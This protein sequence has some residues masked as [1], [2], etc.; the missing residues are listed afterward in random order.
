MTEMFCPWEP[1]QYL[2]WSANVSPLLYYSHFIAFASALAIGLAVLINNR[3][4]LRAKLLM[5]LFGLFSIWLFVDIVVWATNS[6]SQVMF[7]WSLIVLIEVLIYVTAFYFTFVFIFGKLPNKILNSLSSLILL[8]L[9]ILLPTALTLSGINLYDCVAEEGIMA[10][11]YAYYLEII[12]ILGIA[13]I[14]ISGLR[15]N[16]NNVSKLQI[17]LFTLGIVAFLA[18]FA[19]GNIIG[20]ITGDWDLAQYGL[21]G[22]PIF[23]GF[24]GYLIVKFKLFRLKIFATQA[25][26]TALLVILAGLLFVAETNFTRGVLGVTFLISVILGYILTRSVKKEIQQR[27][28]IEVLAE[29]LKKANARLKILDRMKSEFV[30]IA[31]HQLRSP[32]TSIRG[33]ASMLAE[34]TYG[35]IPKKVEDVLRN[36][37]DSSRFMAQSVEDYLNVSRIEAGNMKYEYSDFNLKDQAERIVDELRQVAMKKGLAM[38]FRSD[39]DGSG[40]VH[41]DIGKVR[42]VIMNLIDNSMKYTKEGSITVLAHDDIKKKTV[43]VTI[44]D[45]GIG[46]DKETLEEV[47]E[48]F[49]RAK[50]ANE[51]NVTGTGL[52][53]FVAKKMVDQMG[54]RVWAESDGEGKG[55]TFHLEFKA[56]T[57][58]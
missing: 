18:A 51:V 29:R 15:N 37:E 28:E 6:A 41:A 12:A 44:Q 40:M 39:I 53:L 35:K 17:I 55:S 1:A 42:Q 30:S 50:N 23:T 22:M 34:G 8:P 52:G 32:L 31:S 49:I 20:S 45:T 4:T 48:K 56:V 9:I 7:W 3:E 38:V 26:I 14:A 2:I 5:L 24:L 21:F 36:I 54:G 10:V 27:E 33:Y 16:N 46:M 13:I 11:N 58:T 57:G 47:F 19:S 25:L 43:T